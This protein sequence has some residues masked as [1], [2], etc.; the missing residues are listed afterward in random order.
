MIE[1]QEVGASKSH[2]AQDGENEPGLAATDNEGL[3]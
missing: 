2:K 1:Q 3:P